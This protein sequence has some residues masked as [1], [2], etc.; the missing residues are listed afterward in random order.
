MLITF[1]TRAFD[2]LIMLTVSLI[3]LP[4][5]DGIISRYLGNNLKIYL[6][7]KFGNKSQYWFG[8]LGVIIHELGHAFFAVIFGHK[9]GAIK[10]LNFQNQDGT[11]GSVSSS[12]N[13]SSRYQT[14]G[15]FFIGL[16][17]IFSGLFTFWLLVKLLCHPTYTKLPTIP[18]TNLTMKKFAIIVLQST[19]NWLKNI[20]QAFLNTGSGQQLLLII[21]VGMIS[22]TVFSLSDADLKATYTG[23]PSYMFIVFILSIVSAVATIINPVFLLQLVHLIIMIAA[24]WIIL[25]ILIL[26]CL[27]VSLGELWVG[28]LFF[29]LR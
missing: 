8:G 11:L 26:S 13:P 18:L 16:A 25:L 3:G 29:K 28:S 2:L 17:P 5:L 4:L 15:N 19:F 23:L 21:L 10:L 12:Y 1:T 7:Q 24:L 27:L 9:I 22:S 20:Y 6:V 14:I